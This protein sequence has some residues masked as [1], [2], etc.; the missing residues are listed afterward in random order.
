MADPAWGRT[1]EAGLAIQYSLPRAGPVSLRPAQIITLVH[2]GFG[3]LGPSVT[4]F[5]PFF[6]FFIVLGVT[7]VAVAWWPA[8]PN[9]PRRV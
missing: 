5:D 2:L 1:H 7:L 4:K 3:A 8:I 9:V 6:F